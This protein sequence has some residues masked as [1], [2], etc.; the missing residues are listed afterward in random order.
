MET[1]QLFFLLQ[2]YTLISNQRKRR[3]ILSQ[4]YYQMLNRLTISILNSL[5]KAADSLLLKR[6]KNNFSI[7]RFQT[8]EL[9]NKK[10]MPISSAFAR[11]K[12]LG[13]NSS[14]HNLGKKRKNELIIIN[15][16]SS[17][18]NRNSRPLTQVI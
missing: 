16:I 10:T 3:I 17:S 14:N 4:I 7:S 1:I 13:L 18:L 8:R 12:K 2:Q 6:S 5:N 9:K 11:S 15:S